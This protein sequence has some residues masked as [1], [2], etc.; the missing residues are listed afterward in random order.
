MSTLAKNRKAF[1]D[2]EILEEIEAGLVLKG[3][4]VK[5][6]KQGHMSL[7]GAFVSV[8]NEELF[9]TNSSTPLY[10]H[11]TVSDYNPT[12]SKKLLVKR[13]QIDRLIGKVHTE[14]L[15]LVPLSVYNNHGKI[16]LKFALAR[17]K[18][19][20]DKRQVIKRREDDV[21]IGRIMKQRH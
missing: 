6:I 12:S 7:K 4:E 1:F 20:F 15:T 13:K 17:G 3:C 19:K 9:L 8:H 11:A 14:G 18:K 2:Y 16:K 21:R 5:T 10:K